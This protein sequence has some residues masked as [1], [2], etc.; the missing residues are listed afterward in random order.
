M[1]VL[2]AFPIPQLACVADQQIVPLR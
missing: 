2:P 1:A